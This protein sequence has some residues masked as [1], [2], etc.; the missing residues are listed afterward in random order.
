MRERAVSQPVRGT[1][2]RRGNG[3]AVLRGDGRPGSAAVRRASGG[4]SCLEAVAD[5]KA[6]L[7]D[8]LA[9]IND[10]TWDVIRETHER[11]LLEARSDLA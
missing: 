5:G 2:D 4:E 10:A 1:R 3:I 8:A 6:T 7:N 9:S 11:E